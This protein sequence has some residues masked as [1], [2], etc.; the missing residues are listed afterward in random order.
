[1]T[2][3]GLAEAVA[4][5]GVP[6]HQQTVAKIEK[7][8]RPLRLRE[9]HAIAGAMDVPLD[10]LVEDPDEADA[11]GVLMQHIRAVD[12]AWEDLVET[13]TRLLERLDHLQGAVRWVA[14]REGT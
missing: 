5:H 10:L 8:Q 1:M 11:V 3:E 7:G 12:H 9:A 6:F 4:E 13:N 14:N 2:Q